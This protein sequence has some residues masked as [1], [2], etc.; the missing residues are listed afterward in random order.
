MKDSMR[1]CKSGMRHGGYVKGYA[2]GGPVATDEFGN[3]TF[4]GSMGALGGRMLRGEPLMDTAPE[5][6]RP[7]VNPADVKKVGFKQAFAAAR[8][9][10]AKT[11][12]WNGKKYTT[13]LAKPK[14]DT[15]SYSLA[16]VESEV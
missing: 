5:T 16:D 9:A 12:M 14:E 8:R 7:T 10:G 3:P 1:H 4:A 15:K 2:N 6:P 13:E 11:F